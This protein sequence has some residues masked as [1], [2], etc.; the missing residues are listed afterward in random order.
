MNKSDNPAKELLA[1]YLGVGILLFFGIIG[2]YA[3]KAEEKEEFPWDYMINLHRDSI[4]V[5]TDYGDTL[6]IHA[7]SLQVFIEEDNL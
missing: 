1:I 2:H 6:T 3:S 5:V 7:D 4:I